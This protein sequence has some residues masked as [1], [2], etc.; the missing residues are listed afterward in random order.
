MVS[1]TDSAPVQT[2]RGR[3]AE[4]AVLGQHLDQLLSGIGWVVLVEGGAG[5]GKS[6]LLR[7]VAAMAERLSIG[8]GRGVAD[9]ANAVVPMSVLMEALFEGPPPIL[10]RAA[11][12]DAHASPE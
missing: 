1:T 4:L 3:D 10:E 2:V 9:P 5:I 11:L 7:E 6:R 12:G 8:D